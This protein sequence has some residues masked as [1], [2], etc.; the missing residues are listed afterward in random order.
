MGSTFFSFFALA[1][2][3]PADDHDVVD[4][5]RKRYVSNDTFSSSQ[6]A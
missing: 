3:K 1:R 5:H 4:A 6:R 2:T